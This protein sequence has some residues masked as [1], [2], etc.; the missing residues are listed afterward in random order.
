M[1]IAASFGALSVRAFGFGAGRSLSFVGAGGGGQSA[2]DIPIPWPPGTGAGFL[3]FVY[4]N[5]NGS[6]GSLSTAGWT[7][8]AIGVGTGGRFFW[9]L[10]VTADLTATAAMTNGP[11]LNTLYCWVFQGAA[12]ARNLTTQGVPLNDG[13][14]SRSWTG[15]TKGADCRALLFFMS[16]NVSTA[17]TIT[18]PSLASAVYYPLAGNSGGQYPVRLKY[19]LVAPEYVDGTA[20]SESYG[21]G[22]TQLTMAVFEVY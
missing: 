22:W 21:S 11:A 2:G 20:I 8:S 18:A 12:G 19:D 10:L 14:T 15:V 3:G 17:Q 9:K 5:N 1:P 16:G 4:V 7:E 6:P 13:T